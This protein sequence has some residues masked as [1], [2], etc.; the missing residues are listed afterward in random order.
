MEDRK[1]LATSYA[2]SLKKRNPD[3]YNELESIAKFSIN[4]VKNNYTPSEKLVSL[5]RI[6][7]D[8]P[9][10]D[11][12]ISGDT[13]GIRLFIDYLV[14]PKDEG[15]GT[16]LAGKAKKWYQSTMDSLLK[17]YYAAPSYKKE[18]AVSSNSK[19]IIESDESSMPIRKNFKMA[20]PRDLLELADIFTLNNFELYIVGGAVRDAI[21]GKQPKDYDVATNAKPEEILAILRKHPEYKTL[22][23]GKAFGIINV[24]TA[25]GNE[26]EVASFRS[27]IGIGRRP[28]AVEFTSIDKDVQ[29][30]DL[31]YNALF[32]DIANQQIV[33]YVGGL[34]D[35]EN[36]VVRAVGNAKE[37]FNEDRLRILRAIRFTARFGAEMDPETKQAII[38]DNSLYGV[39]GE[40]IKDELFKSIISAK[41]VKHLF[42]MYTEFDLWPQIYPNLKINNNF[43]D[44]KNIPVVLAILLKHNNPKILMKDLNELKYSALETKQISF[45]VLFQGLD[46]ENAYQLK[47]LWDS[48]RLSAEDLFL[49]AVNASVP[50]KSLVNAF[51]KYTPSVSGQKLMDMGF[52]GKELGQELQRLEKQAF[53]S[54]L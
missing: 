6:M 11:P 16:R 46:S 51:N 26:Y 27:D 39:S 12:R 33:D 35:L 41:S 1:E 10:M 21:L 48:T 34:K 23:I 40:R 8:E 19:L 37:R 13:H 22:E 9:E 52:K 47:K 31:T 45:L 36:N 5:N 14:D 3:L 7:N 43:V 15:H 44:I 20:I 50:T 4:A 49:F 38:E 24:I 30:R 32:Y 18:N 54:L 29:R 2:K 17:K 28:D 25:S 53:E 42:H